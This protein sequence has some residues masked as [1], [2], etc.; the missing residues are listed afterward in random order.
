MLLRLIR[1]C[2]E[3]AFPAAPF[4]KVENLF[5]SM[6]RGVRYTTQ[7]GY[8]WLL[9][10]HPK[11]IWTDWVWNRET[12][13]KCQFIM[14]LIMRG[15]IQTKV[16]LARVM[17]LDTTYLATSLSHA[18]YGAYA[19]G[20]T[21]GTSRVEILSRLIGLKSSRSILLFLGLLEMG[22]AKQFPE[23]YSG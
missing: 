19:L 1:H 9:G 13:P 3:L 6:P 15:R 7:Q 14:W 11:P 18:T 16:R 4:S 20:L 23:N 8:E 2:I 21:E 12:L 10:E 5:A 17:E 22:Q